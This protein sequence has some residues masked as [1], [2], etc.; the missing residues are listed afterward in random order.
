MTETGE[1]ARQIRALLLDVEGTT[2][3]VSFVY[4]VLFPY[5]RRHLDRYLATNLGAPGVIEIAALLGDEWS[6]DAGR[7]ES[8]PRRRPHHNDA[9][10]LS[11]Y[12]NWLMDRDRKSPALKLLQG[13][14][15]EQ[16]YD[17]G[18]LRGEVFA[19]VPPAFA[20]WRDAGL[21]IAIYSSGSVLAQRLLFAHSD[22]GDLTPFVA[23][24]FDT[25]MGPKRAPESYVRIA[26]S[27]DLE[28]REIAFV[29]DVDAELEAA[30]HAGCHVVMCVRP[31]NAARVSQIA[32]V[33]ESFDAID[34]ALRLAAARS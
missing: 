32:P 25:A 34:I 27:L 4:D 20:R 13:R 14:I 16:G 23:R 24:Y 21:T 3:P 28:A 30:H 26:S 15:W 5:A 9:E 1:G 12:L 10:S 31:G 8:V 6:S 33:V 2:T 7:G 18:E 19:D 17:D 11:E 22:Q 29:S